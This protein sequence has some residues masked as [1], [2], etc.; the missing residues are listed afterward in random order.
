MRYKL[1]GLLMVALVFSATEC[2]AACAFASCNWAGAANN[3]PDSNM[4]ACHHHSE[5]SSH[6]SPA[7]CGHEFQLSG[8]NASS[9]SHDSVSSLLTAAVPAPAAFESQPDLITEAPRE[10]ILSP[11]KLATAALLVLRI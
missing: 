11:P 6:Q 8:P 4:L 7:P 3:T 5:R 1:A 2:A 10:P 9:I